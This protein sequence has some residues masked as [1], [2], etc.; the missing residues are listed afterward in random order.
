MSDRAYIEEEIAKACKNNIPLAIFTHHS[1]IIDTGCSAPGF[2]G[3]KSNSAFS[4]DLSELYKNVNTWCYG[5]THWFHDMYIHGTHIVSNQ[6]G[7]TG[8]LTYNPSFILEIPKTSKQ[9][10]A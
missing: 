10:K 6:K 5:H 2:W 1:P 8:E 7:Y 9:M 3:T 4:T